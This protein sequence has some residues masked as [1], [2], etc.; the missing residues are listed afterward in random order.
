MSADIVLDVQRFLC[1]LDCFQMAA[2]GKNCALMCS[3]KL[4]KDHVLIIILGGITT[5]L[6]NIKFDCILNRLIDM[7]ISQ[8]IGFLFHDFKNIISHHAIAEIDIFPFQRQDISDS[9]RHVA[10][11][12]ERQIMCPCISFCKVVKDFFQIVKLVRKNFRLLTFFLVGFL[13]RF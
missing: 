1:L 11:E 10:S 13:F 4:H 7:R 5:S 9:S 2:L 6:F 3:G 8:L 12:C